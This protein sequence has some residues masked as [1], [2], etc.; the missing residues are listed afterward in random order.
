V[1]PFIRYC[2]A[3]SIVLYISFTIPM[4]LTRVVL[5]KTGVITDTGVASLVVWLAALT[6]PLIVHLLV[7]R[8]PLKALYERPTWATLPY[9]SIGLGNGARGT[10]AAR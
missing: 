4:A 9:A 5:L 2:G 1:A 6:S 10:L 7:K 8:T 3:N